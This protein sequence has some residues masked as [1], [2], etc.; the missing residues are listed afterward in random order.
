MLLIL[1]VW[2][3]STGGLSWVI[4]RLES[5]HLLLVLLISQFTWLYHV[6][7]WTLDSREWANFWLLMRVILDIE[8]TW[9]SSQPWIS[10]EGTSKYLAENT[11]TACLV[12]LRVIV[13][14][15]DLLLLLLLLLLLCVTQIS[16]YIWA[17]PS[18]GRLPS[19]CNFW[20]Q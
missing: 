20:R 9:M 1:G 10:V 3:G 11:S 17:A 14:V 15:C 6:D 4:E 2:S 8:T 12:Y 7:C 16:I 18:I 19:M 13:T 5:H